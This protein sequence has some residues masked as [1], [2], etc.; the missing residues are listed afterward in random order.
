VVG[1]GRAGFE[2]NPSSRW[3]DKKPSPTEERVEEAETTEYELVKD[4][5]RGNKK[6]FSLRG[7]REGKRTT[8]KQAVDEKKLNL[9]K[10]LFRRKK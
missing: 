6:E 2:F 10:S 9:A 5:L 4:D 8:T 3:V 1:I 7:P